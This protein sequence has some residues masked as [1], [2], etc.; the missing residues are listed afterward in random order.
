MSKI[1][2]LRNHITTFRQTEGE[3]LFEAWEQY[4]DMIRLCPYHGLEKWL[5]IH[6]FDNGML[7]NTRM[8]IN[9]A[10]GSAL[11]DKLFNEAYHL[12]RNMAHN[13]YQWGTEC[14]KVEKTPQKGGMFEVNG[15]DM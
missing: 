1:V 9:A 13:H 10:V 2:M 11:M 12:I 6:T 4:K 7:Y 8:A 14:A 15:L 5:I 3:S